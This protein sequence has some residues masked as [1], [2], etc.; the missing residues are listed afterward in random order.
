ME[1]FKLFFIIIVLT[2]MSVGFLCFSQPDM[3]RG[4]TKVVVGLNHDARSL[5]PVLTMDGTTNRVLRHLYDDLFF[6]D[7]NMRMIPWLAKSYEFVDPLTWQIKLR[8]GIKFHNGEPFNAESVKFTID[9][10]LDPANK[11]LTRVLVATVNNVEIVDD[12]TVKITTKEPTPTLIESLND[13]FMAPPTLAKEKG[14]KYLAE[15]P[16]GT[17]AYKFDSWTKDKEINLIR[18]GNYWHG[19]PQIDRAVFRVIPEVGPRVSSLMVGEV[20][21][22]PDVPPHLIEQIDNSGV[23]SV[24]SV[25]G[26]LIIAVGL[27]NINEGPMNDI[28]VRQAMNY[29]VNVDEI[30]STIMEGHAARMPGPLLPINKHFDPSL[31]PYPYD[32]EMA[33]S[34]LKKAGYDKGLNLTFHA[35]R[36]RYLKDWEIAQAVALQLSRIGVNVNVVFHEWGNFLKRLKSHKMKDM[37]MLGRTDRQLEGAVMRI[38]FESG[39]SWVNFSDPEVD[40]KIAKSMPIMDPVKRTEAFNRLQAL[41]QWK[42]PWIFLW[43]QHDLYGVNKRLIWE[44]RADWQL[45]LFDAR[46]TD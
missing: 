1:R 9:F 21:L 33:K 18:N 36:G 29:G 35:C 42:A 45:N 37:Y 27:D 38:L 2:V 39:A 44:P 28:R 43:E 12:Y 11:A 41:I 34:L 20:D 7:R 3:A 31:K 19:P 6:R 17:G 5:D 4:E 14:M 26:R 24:K 32:P 13:L 25:A 40:K 22:I 8:K 46:V 30:I 16:V 23:A 10:V 15:H